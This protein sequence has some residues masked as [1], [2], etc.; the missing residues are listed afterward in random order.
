MIDFVIKNGKLVSS[1]KIEAGDILINDGVV[2]DIV[3]SGDVV[4]A[5]DVYDATGRYVLPGLIDAHVHFRTPGLTHKEDFHTGSRAAIYGGVT[6]V[7]DMPN[8]V[9][10]TATAKLLIE[11]QQMAAEECRVNIGFFALLTE[12]NLE[13]MLPMKEAGAVAYKIFLGTSTGN[14]AAPSDGVML[15]QFK[16]AKELGMCI[17]FHAENN[18]INQYYSD[19]LMQAGVTTADCLDKAR[20]AFS[21]VEAVSKAIA[22]A[23]ETGA[24]IHIFHVSAGKTVD[25]IRQARAQGIDITCETAPQYLLLNNTAYAQKGAII[26]A[27]PVIKQE[28]DRLKL[29]EGVS[30][31][32]IDMIAT[33]H[34][35]H[36]P[37]EKEGDV[38]QATA[39]IA[40][41][42]ISAK[43]MLN[44]VSNGMLSLQKYV[45]LMCERPADIWQLKG[46]GYIRKGA[47]ANITVVDLAYESVI[48][49]D[50]LH[51]KNNITAF[52]G[53]PVKGAPVLTVVN[54]KKYEILKM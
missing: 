31:G 49:N 2:A 39:G 50:E 12:D 36:T 32:T 25:L 6:S 11:R 9:P 4:E 13:E 42:E 24:K 17:G 3:P 35:P 26:K 44:A 30:D 40:G 29:W 46:Q 15:E 21:E 18:A 53:T 41:V 43:L 48:R 38:W 37:Q 22:F 1:S 27:Y 45:E 34:A 16:R 8:V 5:A 51:G 47:P 28:A 20:P 19:K 23:R 10:V 33:D 54:G 7:L 14:I 52:D